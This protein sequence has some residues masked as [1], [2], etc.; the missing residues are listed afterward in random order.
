MAGPKTSREALRWI[1]EA[2]NGGRYTVTIHAGEWRFGERLLDVFD[3]HNAVEKATGCDPYTNGTPQHG[4]TAWRVFGPSV[5]DDDDRPSISI[6][7]GIEAYLDG[8]RHR[9]VICTIFKV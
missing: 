8:K 4:G 5:G 9:C 3:V 6:A 7:V 1:Q 2:V